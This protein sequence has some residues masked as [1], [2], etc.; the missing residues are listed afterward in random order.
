MFLEQVRKI[1]GGDIRKPTKEK[2]SFPLIIQNHYYDFVPLD[3]SRKSSLY[4]ENTN[5][6]LFLTAQ[7]VQDEDFSKQAA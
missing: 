3:T 6:S 1:W 2:K 4:N 5:L 7:S